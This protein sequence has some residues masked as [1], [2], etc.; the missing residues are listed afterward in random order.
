[1]TTLVALLRSVNVGGR[2]RVPM[3]ELRTMVEALGFASVQTY[4][5]SGNLVFTGTGRPASVAAAIERGIAATFGLQV[6]VL[7]RS[8]RQLARILA[9]NPFATPGVD[10]K[11]V[12][13]T[14]LAGQPAPDRVKALAGTD[15]SFGDDRFEVAGTDIF[16]HC[17]GGYG[18]TKLNNAF[19]ERRTGVVATT[20]NWR[21]VTALANLAGLDIPD[22]AGG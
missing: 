9:S 21:T 4:V 11:T 16:L 3:D 22:P 2:N 5:Q 19:F 18:V 6:P 20:R 7:V 10:P 15:G 12:H 14:F 13:V 8:G 17:P 1:V